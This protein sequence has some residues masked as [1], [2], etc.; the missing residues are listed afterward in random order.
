MSLTFGN[1]EAGELDGLR[2]VDHGGQPRMYIGGASG[3]RQSQLYI[4]VE[5]SWT[6]ARLLLLNTNHHRCYRID[7]GII[8]LRREDISRFY[9]ERSRTV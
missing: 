8:L 5:T 2:I 9:R 7:D 6:A 3:V 1:V 4:L